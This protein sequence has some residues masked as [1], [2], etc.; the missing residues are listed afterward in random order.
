L[1]AELAAIQ[2]F[3]EIRTTVLLLATRATRAGE[4]LIPVLVHVPQAQVNLVDL[5]EQVASVNPV[6]Q[7]T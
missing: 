1:A 7:V 3:Q 5:L 4:V 2:A 6:Q